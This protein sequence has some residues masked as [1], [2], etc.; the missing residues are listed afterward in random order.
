MAYQNRGYQHDSY[1]GDDYDDDGYTQPDYPPYPPGV[2]TIPMGHMNQGYEDDYNDRRGDRHTVNDVRVDVDRRGSYTDGYYDDDDQE[3][4]WRDRYRQEY[5]GGRGGNIADQLPSKRIGTLGRSYAHV[6]ASMSED[7][8]LRKR[9]SMRRRKS[10]HPTLRAGPSAHEAV[11]SPTAYIADE[12]IADEDLMED[13]E[14]ARL[15]REEAIK[16]M[17]SGMSAKRKVRDRVERESKKR[18]EKKVGKC[19]IWCSNLTYAWRHFLSKIAELRYIFVLWRSHLKKIEGFFGTGILSY[20][21]FLKTLFLLN[22]PLFVLSFGFITI[23]QLVYQPSPTVN[24][25]S[26]TGIELLTGAG[27]F[28]NTELYYG[29]YTNTTIKQN[30]GLMYNMQLA[31]LCAG[32]GYFLLCLIILVH[33]MSS[34]FRTNYVEASFVKSQFVAKIFTSWDF[35]ITEKEAAKLR[36][37]SVYTEIVE[38]LAE[39]HKQ[40]QELTGGQRCCRVMTRICTWLLY[41]AMLGGSCYLVFFIADRLNTTIIQAISDNLAAG[42]ATDAL[43]LL[44]MPLC[45]SAINFLLPFAFSILGSIEKYKYPRHELY[46]SIFR[47]IL[48][49]WAI[50]VVLLWFWL[51]KISGDASNLACWETYVG[52]EIYRLVLVDFVFLL[53]TTFISE[54]IRNLFTKCCCKNLGKPEFDIAR[55][56]LDLIYAQGLCW[57]GAF[58]SPLLPIICMFKLFVFFYVKR[59]SVLMNCRASSKAWR[60][61]QATTIFLTILLLTFFIAL[62]AV[63]YS[64]FAI[65]PSTDCGPFRGLANSYQSVLNLLDVWSRQAN[66]SWIKEVVDVIGSGYCR[67]F[68]VCILCLLVYYYAKLSASHKIL[69]ERLKH[70]ISEEGKDK[71]FLLK[72]LQDASPKKDGSQNPNRTSASPQRPT[73]SGATPNNQPASPAKSPDQGGQDAFAMAMAARQQHEAVGAPPQDY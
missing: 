39:T 72:M 43:R 47:T 27:W 42:S 2:E 17:A 31:Y 61:A 29:Y 26:F 69:V 1:S 6:A 4:Y 70:Q 19:T 24:N 3:E 58:F 23:P 66:L 8:V 11:M 34:S 67:A 37:K 18:K 48:L 55:N 50:L 35:G 33:R 57:L 5:G 60:A 62:A 13:T 22:V 9:S 65:K 52:Q 53:L 71:Q 30:P 49:K 68:V 45:I 14:A 40:A 21:I 20:F 10:R 38:L 59:I 32:G 46:I 12:I 56:V 51:N 63:G 15:R 64:I 16:G 25:A 54:F 36:H 44:A 41:F 28:E 7:Q 73:S